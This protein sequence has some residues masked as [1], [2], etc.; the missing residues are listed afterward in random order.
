[1]THNLIIQDGAHGHVGISLTLAVLSLLAVDD[2][3]HAHLGENLTLTQVHELVID[4]AAH[5]HT[6]SS[7]FVRPFQIVY[8]DPGGDAVQAVGYFNQDLNTTGLITFDSTQ[9]V[10]GAGS[11]RFDSGDGS[12]EITASV[13]GVLGVTRG[14]S[15]YWR[16]DSVPDAVVI[17]AA[18]FEDNSIYSG[19]GFA[20]PANTNADDDF[21]ATATPARNAGQGNKCS[22]NSLD[23]PAGSVIDSVKIIYERKY[24]TDAS[25]GISRVKWV[26]N[27]EE[28]P[29][30][31]NTD[32]PL[33]DTVVEVDVTGDRGWT[34]QDLQPGVIEIIDEARRGDT[35]VSHTQSWDYVKIAVQYHQPTT[36]LRALNFNGDPGFQI[37]VTPK[38]SALVLR[39][40]DGAGNS[41][42]GLNTLLTNSDNRIS[43]GLVYHG[44]DN[45]DIV[46]YLNGIQELAIFEA[47][48][49]GFG[50]PFLNLQYGWV[51]S[52]GVDHLCWFDQIYID[53]RDDLSDPG[54]VR[55]TCKSG[56][57]L[58]EDNWNATGGTGA[59]AERPLS[60]TN[61]KQHTA[62]SGVRQTYTLEAVAEGDVDIAAE[63][64][65]GYM[66][67]AWA[68]KGSG[69]DGDLPALIVNNNAVPII[70]STSPKLFKASF[71]SLAYPA[72]AAGIG[73]RS[74]E[75]SADS[76][77]YECGAVVAFAGPDV[78]PNR[79]LAFAE[80]PEGTVLDL[81]DDLRADPPDSYEFCY[82]SSESETAYA[83]ITVTS[84]DH[85]GGNISQQMGE[86][87]LNNSNPGRS[88]I[89]AGVEVQVHVE[90]VGGPVSVELY[91]R[92]NVD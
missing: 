39:F 74:N 4:D 91:H 57:T 76:F 23:V 60:E 16:Y 31:D 88:R 66:G 3:F 2:D 73:M 81:T 53:D 87:V 52:P 58:N 56:A 83:L 46:I 92:L 75:E 5:A 7:P 44:L 84:L 90:I 86:F 72:H 50:G 37:A 64:L 67:W 82:R 29:D 24:D 63:T 22:P 12:L 38:G 15:F 89:S 9:K 49:G 79:I 13:P 80:L 69:D 85:D 25:I 54:D 34:W 68:K 77:L 47:A 1:V 48:T 33:T 28:G 32:M 78:N 27:G 14:M 42:D 30:H 65:I 6:S 59:I 17:A 62:A 10:L 20:D 45:L 51:F 35:D 61:F 18:F 40:V 55:C 70:L 71:T 43:F 26:V 8:L 36:I 21:Y 19:G 41:Y 11:Y